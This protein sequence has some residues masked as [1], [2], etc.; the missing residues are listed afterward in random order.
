MKVTAFSLEFF[1]SFG[2]SVIEL[3]ESGELADLVGN[4]CSATVLPGLVGFLY[5]RQPRFVLNEQLVV[6]HE[7]MLDTEDLLVGQVL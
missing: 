7:L 2:R 6:R 4:V 5:R 3:A 1:H